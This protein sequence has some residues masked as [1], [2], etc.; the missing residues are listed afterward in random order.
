V[1]AR[2]H[3]STARRC[4]PRRSGNANKATEW[5]NAAATGWNN[6]AIGCQRNSCSGRPVRPKGRF[7]G[8]ALVPQVGERRR[9]PCSP[10]LQH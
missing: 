5:N 10:P 4:P 2:L 3:Q 9:E 8:A 7:E 6:T 1:N